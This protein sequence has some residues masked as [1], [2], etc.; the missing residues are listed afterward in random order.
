MSESTTIPKKKRVRNPSNGTK[1]DDLNNTENVS[2]AKKKKVSKGVNVE[3]SDRKD[4]V[5]NDNSEGAPPQPP[6]KRKVS[7]N[8]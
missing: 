3:E 6:K 8:D 2:N 1:N 5:E 7:T 4:M